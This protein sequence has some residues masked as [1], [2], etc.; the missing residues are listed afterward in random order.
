M[1]NFSE[2]LNHKAL[3][4]KPP[5]TLPASNTYPGQIVKWRL[6]KNKNQK[7]FVQITLRATGWPD[8]V[9]DEGRKVVE[10][11]TRKQF[12][13]DYYINPEN[14]DSFYYLDQLLRS[15]GITGNGEASY[16][17]L[18]PELV[19]ADVTFQMKIRSYENNEGKTVEVND[20]GN[21]VGMHS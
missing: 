2:L 3:Q 6:D 16:D 5:A 4:A 13:R 8:D 9:D 18:L 14:P 17:E 11:I 10:D 21:I 7:P 20:I 1:P 12:T 19:G 15:C